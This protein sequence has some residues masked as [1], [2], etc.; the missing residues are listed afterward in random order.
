MGY[1]NVTAPS[2][3]PFLTQNGIKP[4]TWR[5]VRTFIHTSL[6]FFLTVGGSNEQDFQ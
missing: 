1:F 3:D 2:E 5:L 4:I 6:Y